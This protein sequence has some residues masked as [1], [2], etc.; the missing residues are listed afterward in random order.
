MSTM[1]DYSI[2]RGHCFYLDMIEKKKI[3]NGLGGPKLRK[4]RLRGPVRHKNKTYSIN[5]GQ[6]RQRKI[7]YQNT[8][9]MSGE[10]E[11]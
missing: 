1:T 6:K 11:W 9:T 10:K 5:G 3:V 8:H 7:I 2:M 4:G